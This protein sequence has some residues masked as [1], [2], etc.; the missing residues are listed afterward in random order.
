MLGSIA[1]FAAG[2]AIGGAAKDMAMLLAGRSKLLLIYY[3]THDD[4]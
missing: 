1:F 2:S 4:S 3:D